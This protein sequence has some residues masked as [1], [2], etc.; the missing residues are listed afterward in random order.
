[1]GVTLIP[2]ALLYL[3]VYCGCIWIIVSWLLKRYAMAYGALSP[4]A[5][6]ND[7]EYRWAQVPRCLFLVQLGVTSLNVRVCSKKRL[8]PLR[9]G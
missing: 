8:P 1:M 3:S 9:F 5:G 2:L 6:P 4:A 7:S